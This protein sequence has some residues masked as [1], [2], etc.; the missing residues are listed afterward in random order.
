MEI[1]STALWHLH[2]EVQLSTLAQELVDEDRNSPATW[3]ATGN[4]FSAQTEHETAIKFFQRAIQVNPLS[5]N[6]NFDWMINNT[7]IYGNFQ[8]NPNFPYAYT[9]LGHEYVITEE[10]D[11][12]ITAFRNAIRLDSRHYNAWWVGLFFVNIFFKFYLSIVS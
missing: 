10:L 3:C 12:A 9:L 5:W 4:L 8:L 6:I 7:K 11:K 1:Y 2:A